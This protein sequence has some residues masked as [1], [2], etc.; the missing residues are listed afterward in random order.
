VTATDSTSAPPLAGPI[1]IVEDDPVTA[2]LLERTLEKLGRSVQVAPDAAAAREAIAR[3]VPALIILDLVLPDADGRN[4]LASWR[5]TPATANVPVVVLTV[6]A[7]TEICDQCLALGASDFI[8]KPFDVAQLSELAGGLLKRPPKVTDPAIDALTGVASRAALCH[9]FR[10]L[11]VDVQP[12]DLLAVVLVDIDHFRAVNDSCGRQTGDAVLRGVA[13]LMRMSTASGQVVGRWQGDQFLALLPG[14]A[15]SD[16]ADWLQRLLEALR[17]HAFSSGQ[18]ASFNVTFSG[19]VVQAQPEAS[20]E[21][22]VG[23]ALSRLYLAKESGRGRI[24]SADTEIEAPETT[25]LLADDDDVVAAIVRSALEGRGFVVE[26]YGDGAAALDAAGKTRVDLFLLDVSMPRMDGFEL[27]A[28]LR[29]MPSY[30]RVPVAMLTAAGDEESLERAM[31][32]GAD[33]YLVKPLSSHELVARVE[34]LLTRWVE[35]RLHELQGSGLYMRGIELLHGVFDK[36]RADEPLAV[37]DL[38]LLTLRIVAE[39]KENPAKL[40]GQVMNPTVLHDDFLAQHSL[41]S[42]I[43]ATI[44]GQEVGFE[45][46][47]LDWLCVAALLHEVGCVRLPEGLLQKT[48]DLT[49]DERAVLH[50]RPEFSQEIIKKLA[51]EYSEAAD[52][53]LQVHERPDGSG[54]PQGLK[55]DAISLEAQILGAVEVFEALTHNRPYRESPQAASEAVKYLLDSSNT[56]FLDKVLKALIAKIGL[57]PVGSY[58]SLSTDEVALVLEHRE[59]NPMRPLLAVVTDRA[60]KPLPSP[61]ITDPML[62]PQINIRQ[63]V[64]PPEITP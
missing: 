62:N 18:G 48:G 34:R 35:G 9:A 11:R 55:G 33:D 14:V 24:V 60:G 44:V 36:V 42:A 31:A 41:N 16:A 21:E 3:A 2:R 15:Q 64:A 30:S 59:S 25:V 40:L 12:G 6:S 49:A 13:D 53:A 26:R 58:V 39:L 37:K 46:D 63:S 4:L 17:Q 54:Y 29:A 5:S 45:G 23:A 61:R 28:R 1:L 56:Q 19:G 43:L 38:S 8:E 7:T 10:H 57:Y 47:D 27:L 22:N 52:I 51:P 20:C 32:L 50:R